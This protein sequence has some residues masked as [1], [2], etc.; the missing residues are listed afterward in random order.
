MKQLIGATL[1]GVERPRNKN[2]TD[3][4]RNEAFIDGG[5][6]HWEDRGCKLHDLCITCPFEMC[7]HDA[8]SA[9]SFHAAARKQ[10]VQRLVEQAGIRDR[11]SLTRVAEQVG[12]SVRQVYRMTQDVRTA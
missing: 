9:T 5:N 10:E 8:P 4:K 11:E 2:L 1:V 3:R 6:S 7:V 12:L